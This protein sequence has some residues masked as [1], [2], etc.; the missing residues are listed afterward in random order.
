M[1]K[2]KNF[3]PK[4]VAINLTYNVNTTNK[5]WAQGKG[6]H[7]LVAHNLKINL[8]LFRWSTFISLH[9]HSDIIFIYCVHESL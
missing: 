6:L 4:Y 7:M 9:L 5:I 2:Q 1:M 8:D 3:E